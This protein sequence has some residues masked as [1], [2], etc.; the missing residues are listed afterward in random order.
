MSRALPDCPPLVMLAPLQG[1]KAAMML[2]LCALSQ[3]DPHTEKTRTTQ[4]MATLPTSIK[5]KRI[6]R[7]KAPCIPSTK[8]IKNR[9]PSREEKKQSGIRRVTSS[10]TSSP[11]LI[12]V[13]RVERSLLKSAS[14]ASKLICELD[15]LSMKLQSKHIDPSKIPPQDRV[16]HLVELKFCPDTKPCP[17]LKVTTAQHANTLTRFKTRSLSN[18]NRN[19]RMALHIILIGVAGTIYNDYTIKLLSIRDMNLG[20]NQ[21]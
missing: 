9:S 12:L 14:G 15:R 10:T 13:M 18:P 3:A 7:A 4:A 17:I 5:E 20:I 11:C 19:N 2:S 8:R 21:A 6:P 1:T 16:N